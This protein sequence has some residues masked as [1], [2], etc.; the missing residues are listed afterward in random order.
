MK[1]LQNLLKITF[2]LSILLTLIFSSCDNG[3]GNN[4]GE[5]DSCNSP[6]LT[7]DSTGK[8]CVLGNDIL[9]DRED[10]AHMHIIALIVEHTSGENISS[11]KINSLSQ[12]RAFMGAGDYK[13]KNGRVEYCYHNID[14][15]STDNADFVN[16]V[17]KAMSTWESAANITF[18]RKRDCGNYVVRIMASHENLA[19][20]GRVKEPSMRVTRNKTYGRALHELGH[21]LGFGHEHQRP[22]R[23]NFINVKMSNVKDNKTCQNNYKKLPSTLCKKGDQGNDFLNSLCKSYFGTDDADIFTPYDYDSIMHYGNPEDGYISLC[24][25]DTSIDIFD[26]GLQ[27]NTIGQRS[28]LSIYDKA[29]AREVYGA[30]LVPE[31]TVLYDYKEVT[32]NDT[33]N[34]GSRGINELNKKIV[35]ANAGTAILNVSNI[36]ISNSNF[37]IDKTSLSVEQG[38][39]IELTISF[40]GEADCDQ[41]SCVKTAEL[42]FDTNDNRDQ[43]PNEIY[44]E[45]HYSLT[46]KGTANSDDPRFDTI[47]PSVTINNLEDSSTQSGTIIVSAT[48]TDEHLRTVEFCVDNTN[49]Q[50]MTLQS[51]YTHE[52]TI[53]WDTSAY[54]DGY[55]TVKVVVTDT[56]SNITTKTRNIH[57]FNAMPIPDDSTAPVVE[58]NF[59]ND[60]ATKRDTVLIS[61]T[62]TD[63][64]LHTVEFCIDNTNCQPMTLQSPYTHEYIGFWNTTAVSDGSHIITVKG[65][66]LS[67]NITIQSRE[68]IVDNIDSILPEFTMTSHD[69][70]ANISGTVTLGARVTGNS[71]INRIEYCIDRVNCTPLPAYDSFLGYWHGSWDS[72][73]V[74]NGLHFVIFRAY[75]NDGNYNDKVIQLNVNN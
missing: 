29:A 3:G 49:C 30:P 66:D 45:S 58:I 28:H 75:Q 40:I 46:L 50:T 38:Q 48:A 39:N 44:N 34:L 55:H 70:G 57:V 5:I 53:S 31:I 14:P 27:N 15:N 73:S 9:L 62:V 16:N 72:T 54:T 43:N 65:K 8:Y 61:A 67:N 24:A 69:T 41:A 74:Q 19:T 56:N 71:G 20:L 17:S 10:P 52:Y 22:D 18:I 60:F 26:A 25:K 35:F 11:K 68:I 13:W 2:L 36:S 12:S 63:E 32:K 23:D 42:T 64:H 4:N 47:P 6:I 37:T 1:H 7:E 33:L 21:I 51:P 59:L